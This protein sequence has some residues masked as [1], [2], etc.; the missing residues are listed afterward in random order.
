MVTVSEET[1]CDLV[2]RRTYTGVVFYFFNSRMVDL[3]NIL[4][5]LRYPMYTDERKC[6]ACSRKRI[7]SPGENYCSQCHTYLCLSCTLSHGKVCEPSS[8]KYYNDIKSSSIPAI[9]RA[10]NGHVESEANTVRYTPTSDVY[11]TSQGHLLKHRNID[12]TRRANDSDVKRFENIAESGRLQ[13]IDYT[14]PFDRQRVKHEIER[15]EYASPNDGKLTRETSHIRESISS[16]NGYVCVGEN[17]CAC[18]GSTLLICRRHLQMNVENYCKRHDALC[19]EECLATAHLTCWIQPIDEVAAGIRINLNLKKIVEGTESLILSCDVSVLEHT[20]W[21]NETD[22]QLDEA[23]MYSYLNRGGR[24]RGIGEITKEKQNIEYCITKL[25]FIRT[26]LDISLNELKNAHIDGN[27]TLTFVALKQNQHLI[28]RSR[29]E[30]VDVLCKTQGVT[31]MT[32]AEIHVYVKAYPEQLKTTGN[33]EDC[34]VKLTSYT[35]KDKTSFTNNNGVDV[36]QFKETNATER[37]IIK[38]TPYLENVSVDVKGKTDETTL[39]KAIDEQV[40]ITKHN[41]QPLKTNSR[42]V[43]SSISKRA[44]IDLTTKVKDKVTSYGLVTKFFLNETADEEENEILRL[45]TPVPDREVT[46]SIATPVNDDEDHELVDGTAQVDETDSKP[47]V[48]DDSITPGVTTSRGTTMKTDL[49]SINCQSRDTSTTDKVTH[50]NNEAEKGLK[51]KYNRKQTKDRVQNRKHVMLR[52]NH[53]GERKN[54]RPRSSRSDER[55]EDWIR[56]SHKYK[57]DSRKPDRHKVYP[58]MVSTQLTLTKE[59]TFIKVPDPNRNVSSAK[60]RATDEDILLHNRYLYRRHAKANLDILD[61][62]IIRLPTDEGTCEIKGLSCLPDGRIAVSDFRNRSIKVIS[63]G[64]NTALA[65]VLDE[66]PND[67]TT[68]GKTSLMAIYGLACDQLIVITVDKKLTLEKRFRTGCVCKSLTNYNSC[69]YLLCVFNFNTEVRVL[70]VDGV[71]SMRMS[72]RH[73]VPDPVSIT[74]NPHNGVI[75]ISDKLRGVYCVET[76]REVKRFSDKHVESYHAITA[77]GNNNVFV[78]TEQAGGIYEVAVEERHLVGRCI[79][80]LSA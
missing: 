58:E 48:E 73:I 79:S 2:V 15:T 24:P 70:N 37:D 26:N 47:D 54:S 17:N 16:R 7:M 21:L 18:L 67:V 23:K 57:C 12:D 35:E 39:I 71:V 33:D 75:F 36:Q 69:V 74:L 52:Q 19:C 55:V 68:V 40:C 50:R 34:S 28:L 20:T 3:S 14:Y 31:H 1:A 56:E 22:R 11:G 60:S 46:R 76:G 61:E 25:Q 8:C 41:R 30:L 65:L 78:C 72:L 6:G 13:R 51:K 45:Q 38:S 27:D 80:T 43:R 5:S 77:D 59:T 29:Q 4:T 49:K 63:N 9:F 53:T 66:P 44:T 32:P 64:Y 10:L 62:Q 42:K